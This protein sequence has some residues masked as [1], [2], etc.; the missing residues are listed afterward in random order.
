MIEQKVELDSFDFA[1]LRILQKDNTLPH[2][3]IAEKVNLS[4]PS[5]QRRIKRLNET[6][7]IESNVSIIS[8][9]QIGYALTI[10]VTVELSNDAI[11]LMDHAREAFLKAP[12]VQQ[13]YFVSGQ[14]DI[15]LVI[16]VQSM[17]E[18]SE[19]TRQLFFK[20]KNVK[21]F[22]T[23]VCMSKVKAGAELPI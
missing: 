10:I 12:E 7:I 13:C 17:S 23:Y 14:I 1:I 8:G 15:V 19:L 22:N 6:G 20:N 5:V 9:E 3:V 16:V 11:E 21:K 2:R 4:A 18:F